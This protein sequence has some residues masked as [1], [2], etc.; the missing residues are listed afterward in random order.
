MTVVVY[1]VT[2]KETEKNQEK[3]KPNPGH[4]DGSIIPRTSTFWIYFSLIT[5]CST[6]MSMSL[7]AAWTSPVLPSLPEDSVSHVAVD[8]LM[9]AAAA[10]GVILGWLVL[11][12]IGR[13]PAMGLAGVLFLAGWMILASATPPRYYLIYPG[14][15]IQGLAVGLVNIASTIYIA[16]ISPAEW[17]GSMYAMA[18]VMT[19][20]GLLAEYWLGGSLDYLWLCLASAIQPLLFTLA[21]F[22]LP[23]SP[24]YLIAKGNILQ[25]ER[26][27][28]RLGREESTLPEVIA[29][30]QRLQ[31]ERGSLSG[32]GK[33]LR[34]RGSNLRAL[35][36]VSGANVARQMTGGHAIASYARSV[37]IAAGAATSPH[38]ASVILAAVKTLSS[39]LSTSLTNRFGVK[40]LLVFSCAGVSVFLALLSGYFFVHETS[41]SLTRDF[42]WFPLAALILYFFFQDLGI[43]PFPSFLGAEMFRSDVRGLG[44]S[45]TQCMGFV[46]SSFTMA[47]VTGVNLRISLSIF[48]VST[49]I[50]TP[51]LFLFLQDTSGLTLEQAQDTIYN[52]KEQEKC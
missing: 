50:S 47:L 48:T 23:E 7:S 1:D 29:H 13:R 4:Y 14:R 15:V 28:L 51:L 17:R 20:L 45:I 40:K 6:S 33:R 49:I 11:E 41:P 25:A 5:S 39:L 38:I 26:S 44:T 42:T 19:N 27:L 31:A 52:E 18:Q 36:V 37:F 35:S 10:I 24:H 46:A 8:S 3:P 30:I 34:S 12:T 9:P 22:F 2:K 21:S 32:Q 16:E 43:N